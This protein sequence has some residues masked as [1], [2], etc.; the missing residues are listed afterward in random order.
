MRKMERNLQRW[1]EKE[2]LI[3][4]VDDRFFPVLAV[5][6]ACPRGIPLISDF[7]GGI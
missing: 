3:D 1:I 6:M 7:V 4:G 5:C 2:R